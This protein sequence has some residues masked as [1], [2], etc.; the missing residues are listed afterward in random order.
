MDVKQSNSKDKINNR[1]EEINHSGKPDEPKISNKSKTIN[2]NHVDNVY[3]SA[4]GKGKKEDLDD[5][6]L[7]FNK[8]YKLEQPPC[9]DEI[10]KN[11]LSD[12]LKSMEKPFNYC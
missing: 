11:D 4:P 8:S 3:A 2:P 5:S 1:T 10:S 9:H 7:P 12:R 6:K